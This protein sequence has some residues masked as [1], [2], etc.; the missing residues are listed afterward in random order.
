MKIENSLFVQLM[1]LLGPDMN[2]NY[3]YKPGFL[4]EGNHAKP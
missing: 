4:N 1:F 3:M 2:I